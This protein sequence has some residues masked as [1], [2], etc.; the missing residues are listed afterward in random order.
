MVDLVSA[1][2]GARSVGRR[3]GDIFER[4]RWRIRGLTCAS[5]EQTQTESSPKIHAQTIT[6]SLVTTDWRIQAVCSQAVFRQKK[7]VRLAQNTFCLSRSRH[8][9][10]LPETD[11]CSKTCRKNFGTLLANT[12]LANTLLANSRADS[13]RRL[14][15]V[16]DHLIRR[17]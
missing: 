5:D 14:A 11:A 9:L 7:L 17:S 4:A 15:P 1:V 13:W 10:E 8:S 6:P 2:K 3:V 16:G 12:F